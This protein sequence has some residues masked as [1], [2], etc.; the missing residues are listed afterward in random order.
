MGK[1]RGADRGTKRKRL[2]PPPLFF[3]TS[4]ETRSQARQM[5]EV[6]SSDGGRDAGAAASSSGGN[7]AQEVVITQGTGPVR[8]LPGQASH[9]NTHD[10]I[11]GNPHLGHNQNGGS[12]NEVSEASAASGVAESI[13]VVASGISQN[14]N[15]RRRQG[16]GSVD[17]LF[18]GNGVT[19]AGSSSNAMGVAGVEGQS[20]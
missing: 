3:D 11:P 19:V 15:L 1:K 6:L 20:W 4:R 12:A 8:S 7:R 16:E 2:V 5:A 9:D 13:G 10:E 18:R 17:S 14:M